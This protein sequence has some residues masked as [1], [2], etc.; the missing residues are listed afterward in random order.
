MTKKLEINMFDTIQE[1]VESLEYQA[2]KSNVSL[3][4]LTIDNFN[5]FLDDLFNDGGFIRCEKFGDLAMEYALQ[6]GEFE[7][8]RFTNKQWDCI[9]KAIDIITSK[10]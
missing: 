10:Q 2:E 1:M 6:F 5:S 4:G 9:E 8:D 7:S 3:K